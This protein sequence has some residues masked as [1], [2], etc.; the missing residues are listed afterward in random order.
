MSIKKTNLYDLYSPNGGGGSGMFRIPGHYGS[1]IHRHLAKH[2][3]HPNAPSKN[4]VT[5]K[6]PLET[7][8]GNRSVGW[9]CLKS[10]I[11]YDVIIVKQHGAGCKNSVNWSHYDEDI[12]TANG[13]KAGNSR[14]WGDAPKDTQIAAIDAIIEACKRNQLSLYQAAH[15][16]A[17][18]RVES[19]FNPDAAACSTSAAGLGQFI[20]KTGERYGL[21]D[22]NRFEIKPSADALVRIFKDNCN[23]ALKHKLNGNELEIAIYQY[24]HDGT[25]GHDYGGRKISKEEVVPNILPFFLAISSKFYLEPTI[26]DHRYYDYA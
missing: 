23:F 11:N 22:D 16:L 10:N 4:H 25:G 3:K 20:D 9:E 12:D 14:K 24:H 21:N 1:D 5:A 19:G 13:R 26:I 15:V 17:I 2:G 8:Y 18:T 7:K 6:P